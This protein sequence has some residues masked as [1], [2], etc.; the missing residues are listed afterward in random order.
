MS[1]NLVNKL[2]DLPLSPGIYIM[3]DEQGKVLYVGKAKVLKNRVSQYFHLTNKSHEKVRRLMSHV[4][5]FRYIITASEADALYLE[6][7]FVK[8]HLPP[9]NIMLKDDKHFPYVRVSVGED[10][11]RVEVTRK[12][13]KDNARYFGPICGSAKDYILLIKEVFQVVS[14]KHDFSKLSKSFRPCLDYHLGRCLAPCAGKISK[15]DYSEIT[16][17]VLEFLKGDDKYFRDTL[18]CNMKKAAENEEYEKALLFR[19]RLELLQKTKEKAVT[20]LN[21]LFDA[22]AFSL[23]TDGN[24]TAVNL[25]CVRNGKVLV[26]ENFA[27]TDGSLDEAQAMSSFLIQY[28]SSN[29]LVVDEVLVNVT[30]EGKD[31][32]QDMLSTQKGKRVTITLPLKG[33]KKSIVALATENV[34]DYIIKSKS[35]IERQFLST[36][37]AV[38]QLKTL[39]GLSKLPSRIECYDISNIS[40]IDKVASMVVFVDGQKK[41]KLYRRFRIKTVDG[42]D[43]FKSMAEVISRRVERIKAG[44]ARF[45]DIPDLIV[46]DGGLGQLHSAQEVIKNSGIAIELI[47][48]AKRLEEVFTTHNNIPVLLPKESYALKLLINLRDEAHRFAITYFRS[49][50]TKNA[51]KSALCEINGI[52]SVRQKTLFTY[53]KTIEQI[54]KATKEELMSLPGIN[55]K[56]ADNIYNFFRMENY[57]I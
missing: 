46:V 43:D 7:N 11:P 24:N 34:T 15:E 12:L 27:I 42:A 37:G 28:Y 40:G 16:E 26:C 33:A 35:V 9:Y 13:K 32:L 54:K 50:H 23:V 10:F 21:M 39:L 55:K 19:D 49:L 47:S 38:E 8:K 2:N 20:Q 53:F 41:Q 4:A 36:F 14:C 52:G 31:A 6:D 17:R 18:M 25:T 30:P 5:D 56:E 51:L 22:D 44:D 48:L 57:E 3:L 29:Q 1:E 45:G